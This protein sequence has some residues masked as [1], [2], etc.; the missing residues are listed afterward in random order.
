MNAPRSRQI[1][2]AGAGIAGLTAAI[3]FARQ[4]FSVQVY[5]Q[6]PQLQEAGAGLQIPPNATRLLSALGALEHLRPAAIA[7]ERIELRSAKRQ[8]LLSSIDL[9]ARAEARWKAPY[10][11]AHRADLQSALLARAQ[12]D[13]DIR[14]VTGARVS[15]AALHARGATVSIDRD[16]RIDEVSCLLL[17][18]ADGVH[19][20][21][22]GLGGGAPADRPSG[23][24][25]WRTTVRR[26][27]RLGQALAE[28]MPQDVVTAFLHRRFHLVAY[29]LRGGTAVNLVAV[30]QAQAGGKADAAAGHA[31]LSA[32]MGGLRG[33][34]ATL[35][36]DAAPWT[37]W[38][39]SEVD[40][41]ISWTGEVGAALIGDA[42]HAMTPFAAQGAAMG[43]EDAVV[44]AELVAARP[45]DMPA[46]LAAY[47]ALRRPRVAR[48]AA[49]GRLNR[50]AYH[51]AGPMALGRNLFM[52][53]R[54]ERLAADLGWL[55]GYDALAEAKQRLTPST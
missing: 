36:D 28:A 3:A 16:G 1:V 38:P 25:A 7:P 37:P 43:I 2:V 51:A 33:A 6:A 30:T 17:V 47:E 44:L 4:G 52:R 13:P 12:R 9:G 27:S 42:A 19:S 50:L 46:A 18:G 40:P 26:D 39:I 23:Y 45:D 48:A 15:D 32:A 8:R 34:L 55:Y 14:I 10:L 29:P 11:V 31:P 49:R 5:E 22:R 35:A 53:L 41:R 20:S 54:G 24:I 21:V